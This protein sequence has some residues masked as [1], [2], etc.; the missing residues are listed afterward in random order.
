MPDKNIKFSDIVEVTGLPLGRVD[1]VL[2]LN[3][4]E[5]VAAPGS[6]GKHRKFGP[7]TATKAALLALLVGYGHGVKNAQWMTQFI[8]KRLNELAKDMPGHTKKTTND[9]K[10]HIHVWILN[11]TCIG[12]DVLSKR[13]QW[14]KI[15]FSDIQT[16]RKTTPATKVWHMVEI[17]VAALY[18]EF[19]E[20]NMN[21]M[22]L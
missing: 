15:E 4:L 9:K 14:H 11:N 18:G 20:R 7:A 10:R 2:K 22:R 1:Y 8:T 6:Q 13:G 5:E 12:V 21:M 16:H 19:V 3:I 17:N